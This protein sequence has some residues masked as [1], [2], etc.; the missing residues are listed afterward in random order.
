MAYVKIMCLVI[1]KPLMDKGWWSSMTW[2]SWFQ[3]FRS[4]LRFLKKEKNQ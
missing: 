3:F 1:Q 4:E 2:I